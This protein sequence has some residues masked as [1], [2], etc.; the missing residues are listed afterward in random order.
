MRITS[1][2]LILIVLVSCGRTPSAERFEDNTRIALPTDLKVTRDDYFDMLQD[3]EILFTADFTDEHEDY[4]I[5]Q[6]LESNRNWNAIN[7][8]Y[9]YQSDNE[10][11]Q[12]SVIIDTV[13]NNLEYREGYD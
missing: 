9:E 5:K 7:I 4:L 10:R 11:L 13:A 6:I 8:G 2:L 12:V 1:V 3:Y